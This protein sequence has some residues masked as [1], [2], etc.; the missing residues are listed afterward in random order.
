MFNFNLVSC[1]TCGALHDD[2]LIV[3]DK[4]FLCFDCM[5]RYEE[6]SKARE[7]SLEDWVKEKCEERNARL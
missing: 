7:V 4:I 5:E 3:S 2:G 6:D 1:P